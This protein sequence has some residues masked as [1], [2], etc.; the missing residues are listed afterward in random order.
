M[1]PTRPYP[2]GAVATSLGVLPVV[3]VDHSQHHSLLFAFSGNV[4][5]FHRNFQSVFCS[6]D[7]SSNVFKSNI[8]APHFTPVSAGASLIDSQH[9]IQRSLGQE[10]H[11]SRI[12]S[13]GALNLR[14]FETWSFFLCKFDELLLEPARGGMV[15]AA[16]QGN[17]PDERW[18]G[19][20]LVT[21]APTRGLPYHDIVMQARIRQMG[22]FRN[23]HHQFSKFKKK[24]AAIAP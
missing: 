16:V 24:K 23:L 13:P 9:K 19:T 21:S 7:L 8:L 5:C 2:S 3:G 18:G 4:L 6:S 1:H 22:V 15:G 12:N 20:R 10:L 11:P 17:L 14:G